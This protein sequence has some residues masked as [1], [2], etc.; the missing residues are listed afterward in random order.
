MRGS[1]CIVER[2]EGFFCIEFEWLLRKCSARIFYKVVETWIVG[3]TFCIKRE[4]FYGLLSDNQN[5]LE[6]EGIEGRESTF[7]RLGWKR[8][9]GACIRILQKRV[10]WVTWLGERMH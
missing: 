4:A 3:S 9:R 5:F 7:L 8:L 10:T 2:R 6:G 1:F